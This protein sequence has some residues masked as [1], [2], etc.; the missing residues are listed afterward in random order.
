MWEKCNTSGGLRALCGS[1]VGETDRR[2]FKQRVASKG[3]VL[4]Q[5]SGVRAPFFY[6]VVVGKVWEINGLWEDSGE[7]PRLDRIRE[8]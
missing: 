8:L 3:A 1:V 2:F 5:A 4:G 6:W 7:G